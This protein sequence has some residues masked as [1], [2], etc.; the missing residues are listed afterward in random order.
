MIKIKNKQIIINDKPTLIMCGEVHYFRL[1]REE[2]QDRL[3]KLKLAGCNAVASYVP[4]VCHEEIEGQIDLTGHTRSELDLAAFIDLCAANDLYFFVRPGPFIM[5]EMKNEGVPF[6]IYENYPETIPLGWDEAKAPTK[7]LDYL[8]P[9]FLKVSKRWY[10]AVM[11]IVKP[12]LQPNGGNIIAVQLDNEVGMLSWVSNTPDLTETV[13][14]DFVKWL[15]E[16]YTGEELAERYPCDLTEPSSIRSPEEAYASQLHFDLGYYMRH[17]FAK[18]IGLLRSYCEEFG[19]KDI[20]FIVN[21]HGTGAGR[22]FT[23]PIGI[24]QLYETYQEPGYV[25]GSDIYF[26]DL[27]MDSFQDLYLING[28][29]DAVHNEDQPLTSVEFNCGDANFGETYGSRMDVSAADLKTRMC[30]AQGNRL[31]NYYLMT[32]GR[33]YRFT[34]PLNDGNDRVAFT[35]E[36]HGFAA[37]ISPEGKLNYTFP[38]MAKSIQTMMAVNDKMA[39]A[40]EEYDRVSFA[41]I[42]DYFMTEYRYPKSKKMEAIYQNLQSNRSYGAWEVMGRAMLLAGYRFTGVD[43][44]NKPIAPESHPVIALPSARYLHKHVQ[45]KLVDYLKAGGSLLVYG[46]LPLYDM[47]GNPCTV[48]IDY[49]GMDYVENKNDQNHY[50]LSLVAQNWAQPRPEVR[51]HH[52][53]IFNCSKG[54]P[55]FKVYGTDE[56]CGFDIPVDKGRVI[57]LTMAYRCD[58]DLFKTALEKLGA[59]LGLRHDFEDHGIFMTSTK[60]EKDERF[61]HVLN[62]DGFDKSFRIIDDGQAIL[63]GQPFTLQSRDGVI[64]PQNIQFFGGKILE[65]TAEITEIGESSLSFRLTQPTDTIKFETSWQVCSSPDYEFSK[66][67]NHVTIT[68]KKHAKIDD[69]LVITF[70]EL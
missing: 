15:Q 55:L 44:Q 7:T 14:N 32:G 68:S 52:A 67:G 64:L 33:N 20:P 51:S 57:T 26:G 69:A 60:N 29:M 21:I 65:S 5:A 9:N 13:L 17:R 10:K 11:E 12:R 8:S 36:R 34:N 48:L 3:D 45:E 46:E 62:L 37:P 41:F 38:R 30:I 18:Y 22:G 39:T 47:E 28:F 70:K 43:I 24:S 53:Q 23:Y 66:V 27:N 59:P 4:W 58:I 63:G 2:W 16:K 49:L 35:G 6:W 25:S 42:P 50:Y 31:L 19:V 54:V 40:N 1:K 56:A 61:I